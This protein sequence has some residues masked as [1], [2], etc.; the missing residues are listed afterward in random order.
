MEGGRR[1]NHQ[2]RIGVSENRRVAESNNLP[3]EK[4]DKGN[5]HTHPNAGGPRI[6]YP[7]GDP[8]ADSDPATV[9]AWYRRHNYDFLVLTDHNHRTL[10]EYA[11]GRRRFPKPLMIPGEEVSLRIH[12]ETI[13]VHLGAIGVNRMVEPVDAADVVA[14]LQANVDAIREAGGIAAINHP[15]LT[16]AF[17]HNHISQVKGASL[18]EVFNGHPLVNVYG[19]GGRPG[20]EEIWAKVLSSGLAI[21]GVAVDDSHQFKGE[22]S[23]QKSTPG[24]GWVVVKAT[25]LDEESILEGLQS[26]QFYSSTGVHLESLDSGPDGMSLR[27]A[28]DGDALYTTRFVGR[29]GLTLKEVFGT[30][31]VFR[32]GGDEGYFRATVSSSTGA[33]AWTQ[34]VFAT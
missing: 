5:I 16:W 19:V 25:A 14:T 13:A 29:G 34:P 15:N 31:A 30:E 18:L 6:G 27:I 12:N 21:W 33:Q 10:L 4:W 28:P 8:G 1:S 3:V 23:R 9:T 24:R 11:A 20:S 7:N 2:N 22:F 32:A 26:G 17:D